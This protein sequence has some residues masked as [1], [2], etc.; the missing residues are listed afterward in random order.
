[1]K[2][3]FKTGNTAR[4]SPAKDPEVPKT[5]S[6]SEISQ[7]HKTFKPFVVKKDTT[8]APVNWFAR[9]STKDRHLPL[10]YEGDVIVVDDG[11]DVERI[12]VTGM[13]AAGVFYSYSQN[14]THC[15]L[16]TSPIHT[17]KSSPSSG[18]SWS[19]SRVVCITVEDQQHCLGSKH[20]CK[21][22]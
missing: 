15:V 3:F 16:R 5:A 22:Q 9:S 8:V 2:N 13:S 6:S 17:S 18:T 4:A 21:A 20:D 7:F 11:N 14:R 1:M 12:D 10:T 19:A